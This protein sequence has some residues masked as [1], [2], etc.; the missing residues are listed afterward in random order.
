MKSFI[1]CLLLAIFTLSIDAQMKSPSNQKQLKHNLLKAEKIK[2]IG[3]AFTVIGGVASIGG[4]IMAS[5]GLFRHYP[6]TPGHITNDTYS[7]IGGVIGL[8]LVIVG[9]PIFCIGVPT[10]TV[11]IIKYHTTKKNLQISMIN[12]KSPYSCNSINGIGLKI[13]F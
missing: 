11:G 8:G 6:S 12:I 1:I 7:T 2:N 5:N 13:R 9:V 3:L 4:G 10:L